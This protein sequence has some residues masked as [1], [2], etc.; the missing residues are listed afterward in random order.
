MSTANTN[1]DP[2]WQGD[3]F[4]LTTR[5]APKVNDTGSAVLSLEIGIKF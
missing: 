1:T 2:S 5:F 3:I 4:N